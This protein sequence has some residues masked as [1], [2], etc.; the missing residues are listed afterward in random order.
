MSF[1][2]RKIWRID[3]VERGNAAQT[4]N[5]HFFNFAPIWLVK[6]DIFPQTLA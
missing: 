6:S 4:A 3:S 2:L 1:A 5:F